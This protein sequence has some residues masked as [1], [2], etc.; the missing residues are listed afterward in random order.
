[1]ETAKTAEKRQW[2]EQRRYVRE[3]IGLTKVEETMERR[4]WRQQRQ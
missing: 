4:Q 1:M 2:G 3:E